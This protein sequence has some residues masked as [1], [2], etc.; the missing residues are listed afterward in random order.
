MNKTDLKIIA[1]QEIFQTRKLS[2]RLD[3]YLLPDSNVLCTHYVFDLPDCANAVALDREGNVLLVKQYRYAC[4]EYVI[5]LPGGTVE[6]ND[7]SM[8][9]CITRELSEETGYSFSNIKPLGVTCLSPHISSNKLYMF[10]AIGGTLQDKLPADPEE[11]IEV[12]KMPLAEAVY[13]VLHKEIL[14]NGHLTCFFYAM[15]E[16]G[17]L[18]E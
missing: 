7:A 11:D 14:A 9:A 3:E 15:L 17:L 4:N 6:K 1:S 16:L 2:L 13:K 5:E 10:L 18:H 12:I 8:E